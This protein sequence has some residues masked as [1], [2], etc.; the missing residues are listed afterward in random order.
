MKNK[1]HIVLFILFLFTIAGNA[2]VAPDKYFVRFTDKNNSPYSI[3]NPSE[4]L[5]QR[6]IQRRLNQGIAIDMTDIPVNPSY[7]QGIVETGATILNPTKWFNGVTI[8]TTDQSVLD[9]IA[10]LPYVYGITKSPKTLPPGNELRSGFEKPFF[11]NEIYNQAV[12]PEVRQGQEIGSFN[13]G[14]SLNQ[15]QMLNGDAL[16]EMG[17][18]GQGMVIAVLDAGFLN[19]NILPVFDSLWDHNQVLGT[20]DFVRGGPIQFDE[21]PHGAM[22]LSCMA[23]NYPGELI[24]T[25]PKASYYL[26]RSEDGETENIIEEYNWVSA[27][28][29]AD[30]A[31][32]DVISSSLGYTQF[33]DPL[34]DHT[35][36][37]MDGNTTPATRGAD[38]A[39][40]KGIQVVN[41]LGNDGSDSWY[42]LSSPSDGDS[43][44]GIGAVDA[45]GD[46]ASFSSHGP[47]FDGRV[48]P[49][50]VSQG[51]GAY[52]ADP[53]GGG[54]TFG[55][56]TSFS[57]PIMA[58]MVACLWQANPSLNNK[59]IADAIRRSASQ[60]TTPDAELGYGIPDFVMA[61]LI[62]GINSGPD[63]GSASF[64][65]Y[66]NPFRNEFTIDAGMQGSGGAGKHEG[67]VE[68]SD[69]TGRLI[70]SQI[71]N[72]ANS[73]ELT[74]D[75]LQN[76]PKGLYF[77]KV[78][79]NG[80]QSIRKVV[81]E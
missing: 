44:L 34:K 7:L 48:K 78:S 56:G 19:A 80:S 43:V 28:E 24:G 30:S 74:I 21:H 10:A 9:E 79:L 72:L 52:V 41:S 77:V 46:Y 18:R 73:N 12:G 36:E 75:L 61:D 53:Y 50:V 66:P 23:G 25:A 11:K 40:K 76:A 6:S 64:N 5:T 54:F 27:A 26:L 65:I 49:D 32:A 15:I 69:V 13:Y 39:C 71:L 20:H 60:Y 38:M 22:T 62:L 8:F 17:Y 63:A 70:A 14:S 33:D 59:Q 2:Q 16:H 29:Y 1:A 55:S 68:I 58:G 81:K 47:S 45:I 42:Y 67:V 31:G 37:E 57:C 51:E 3:D 35:Y 4:F